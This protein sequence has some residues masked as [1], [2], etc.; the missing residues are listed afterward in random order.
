M[1]RWGFI[2]SIISIVS[3]FIVLV[4]IASSISPLLVQ[5]LSDLD[6]KQL[7]R[8]SA[9]CL[10]TE[11]DLPG[12]LL[13]LHLDAIEYVVDQFVVGAKTE[14][15]PRHDVFDPLSFDQTG[16]FGTVSGYA[17]FT[18]FGQLTIAGGQPVMRDLENQGFERAVQ[19]AMADGH[20]RI[21]ELPSEVPAE[22]GA[23]VAVL[24]PLERLGM[25][26]GV[27]SIEIKRDPVGHL[28]VR[29]VQ[30]SSQMTSIVLVVLA[31]FLYWRSCPT[32]GVNAVSLSGR[33]FIWLIMIR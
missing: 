8:K 3:A 25:A 15:L 26:R 31:F 5:K 19:A 20:T 10:R 17:V 24:I 4:I 27:V 18:R 6:A 13:P 2:A 29:G 12:E 22:E 21:F 14:K 9:L 30:F 28:M 16:H 33:R 11:F 1:S 7:A 32:G 23:P